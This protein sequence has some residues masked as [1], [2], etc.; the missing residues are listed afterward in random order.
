MV[1]HQRI[2]IPKRKKVKLTEVDGDLKIGKGAFLI[3][4]KGTIIVHGRIK[5]NGGF[6]CKGNLE[7]RSLETKSGSV[8]V[9]GDLTCQREV[10]IGKKLIVNGKNT[11]EEVSAGKAVIVSK[12][13]KVDKIT[14][15][16]RIIIKGTNNVEQ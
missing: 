16:S 2:E 12:G 1:I 5:N 10:T 9:F 7:A 4:E 6:K 11:A 15:G 3:A 13:A 8:F 14:A